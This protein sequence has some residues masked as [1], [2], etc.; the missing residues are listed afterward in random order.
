MRGM[1]VDLLMVRKLSLV[2]L[3]ALVD[4]MVHVVVRE[5]GMVVEMM[6]TQV[7]AHHAVSADRHGGR[8]VGRRGRVQTRDVLAQVGSRAYAARIA[9]QRMFGSAESRN[10]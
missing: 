7:E 2:K 6:R 4:L 9:P 3:L 8:V 1:L 10:V 5:V